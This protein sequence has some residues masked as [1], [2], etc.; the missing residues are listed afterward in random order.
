MTGFGWGNVTAGTIT[1]IVLPVIYGGTSLRLLAVLRDSDDPA[2]RDMAVALAATAAASST[3]PPSVLS[4]FQEVLG[5]ANYAR[6]LSQL[7]TVVAAGAGNGV[8]VRSAF[9][10]D[11][12]DPHIQHR[13]QRML[14]T[15]VVMALL[16]AK[17]RSL[18]AELQVP[19]EHLY[20]P[21]PALYWVAFSNFMVQ[22]AGD[23]ARLAFR[24]STV[25]RDEALRAG[26]RCVG[27]GTLVMS[28][29][30]GQQAA[31]ITGHLISS[32]LP[33][34]L[35]GVPAQAVIG[36]SAAIVAI[37]TSLPGLAWRARRWKRNVTDTRMATA[38]ESLWQSFRTNRPEVTLIVSLRHPEVRLYRRVMEIL[39]GLD[40]LGT[41]RD[42]AA[43]IRAQ[44]EAVGKERGLNR[45]DVTALARAA[46]VRYDATQ[47]VSAHDE[48]TGPTADSD[49]PL[50]GGEVDRDWRQEARRLLKTAL[51]LKTTNLPDE[52]VAQALRTDDISEGTADMSTQD[53]ATDTLESGECSCLEPG[54][55]EVGYLEYAVGRA[56]AAAFVDEERGK[57][58]LHGLPGRAQA[59]VHA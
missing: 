20:R 58:A 46:L 18:A 26:L 32:K 35:R 52:V 39:D 51:Y 47:P 56:D 49:T 22:A 19:S 16:F 10:P 55:D 7:G 9:P 41:H 15:L 1:K 25:T 33:Q 50:T 36:G 38:L 53:E 21:M 34:P 11:E 28:G 30:Y 3:L 42:P 44:A 54:S 48:L 5:D 29:F 27:A 12:A 45:D 8:L 13:R 2:V 57:C 24:T 4:T 31:G 17:D 59:N 23:T 40:R 43:R 37:G 6:F 14:G